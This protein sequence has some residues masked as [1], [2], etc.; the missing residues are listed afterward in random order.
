[1]KQLLVEAR[2]QYCKII[3]FSAEFRDGGQ[4][5]CT[6]CGES[7]EVTTDLYR[8][9]SNAIQSI[10]YYSDERRQRRAI[11]L[12]RQGMTLDEIAEALGI[13]KTTAYRMTEQVV[14]MTRIANAEIVHKVLL[15][16]QQGKTLRQMQDEIGIS[17]QTAANI[18]NRYKF[19]KNV[20][21]ETKLTSYS[22]DSNEDMST[23]AERQILPRLS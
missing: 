18:L 14:Y 11:K 16:R 19:V 15:S 5:F 23:S 17:R 10:Y 22:K 1:M 2:C 7:L 21:P 13:S 3:I 20:S 4:H 9:R 8:I 6:E 12:R